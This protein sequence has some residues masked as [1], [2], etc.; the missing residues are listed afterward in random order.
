MDEQEIS[1]F[2][3]E[4][5]IIRILNWKKHYRPKVDICDETQWS[6]TVRIAEIVFEKYGDNS[7]PKSWEI[8]CNAIEKL[9]NKPFT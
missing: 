7:Y 8:Y 5:E 3:S 9:I 4:L 2:I 6:I 1:E